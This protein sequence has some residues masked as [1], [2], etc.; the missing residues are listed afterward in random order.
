MKHL[1]HLTIGRLQMHLANAKTMIAKQDE[2]DTLSEAWEVTADM[3]LRV[4]DEV[5]ASL[6]IDIADVLRKRMS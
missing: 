1:E 6:A 5:R 3:L 2:L 4:H